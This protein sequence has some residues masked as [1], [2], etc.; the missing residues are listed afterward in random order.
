MH[1]VQPR[2]T[3]W[4]QPVLE[5]QPSLVQGLPSLQLSAVPAVHA[6]P[7]QV[8]APLQTLPSLQAVPFATAVDW[9]WPAVQVSV[10]QGFPSLHWL[11]V[12]QAVQPEMGV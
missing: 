2:I 9:Q 10:V 8:S 7:W 6:P 5:L 1:A 4:V 12:V 11:A 3:L